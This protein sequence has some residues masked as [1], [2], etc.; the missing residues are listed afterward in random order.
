M[1]NPFMRFEPMFIQALLLQEERYLVSQTYREA[2][3][4]TADEQ[5]IYLLLSQYADISHARIHLSAIQQDKY[6]AI[7]DLKNEAHKNKLLEM[8]RPES[9]YVLYITIIQS[10]GEAEKR[11]NSKYTS[12]IRRYIAQHTDWQIGADKT[13]TPKLEITYGQLFVSL[14]YHSQHLRVP[15]SDIEKA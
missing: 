8:M 2:Y 12:H 13:I 5:K 4:H 10:K 9:V 7:V 11:L 3:D 14:K 1:F 6:A 15:L